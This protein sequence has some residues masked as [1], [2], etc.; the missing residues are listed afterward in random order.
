[1][2]KIARKN[3]ITGQNCIII[4]PALL[5]IDYYLGP[6]ILVQYGGVQ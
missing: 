4:P 2:Q 1:L 3:K 6:N 5:K